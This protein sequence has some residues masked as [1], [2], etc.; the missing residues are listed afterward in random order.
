MTSACDEQSLAQGCEKEE[1][2][3]SPSNCRIIIYG[4]KRVLSKL[5]DVI[6]E[7]FYE[8]NTLISKTG[9]Y[10]KPVHKVYKKLPNGRTR[11]YEYY[12][13]YWWSK[14]GNRWK[15]AGREKPSMIPGKPPVHPL[16]GLS[17]IVE[18]NDII[19]DCRDFERFKK[20]FIG[21][22]HERYD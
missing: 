22:K 4:G 14:D 16:E 21:L 7:P 6:K 8:Y 19:I 17:I 18:G 2:N 11:I 5:T 10:L 20:Y 9:Y 15:Y 3:E 13:R 12:G 1:P